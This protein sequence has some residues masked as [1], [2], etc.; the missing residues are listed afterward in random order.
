MTIFAEEQWRIP[1]FIRILLLFILSCF[2][3]NVQVIGSVCGVGQV[4][5]KNLVMLPND[6]RVRTEVKKVFTVTE[7]CKHTSSYWETCP[8]LHH[9]Q[10]QINLLYFINDFC[11]FMLLGLYTANEL[12]FFIMDNKAKLILIA[13]VFLL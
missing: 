12:T 2:R 9:Y 5:H 11:N 4:V 8:T 10:T 7:L 1:V 3:E 6:G 13:V